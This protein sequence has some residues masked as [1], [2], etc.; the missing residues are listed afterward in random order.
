MKST[1]FVSSLFLAAALA[2]GISNVS[3]SPIAISPPA[4]K[5]GSNFSR[6]PFPAA[7][8][9][10][11]VE[12]PGNTIAYTPSAN[13]RTTIIAQTVSTEPVLAPTGRMTETAVTPVRVRSAMPSITPPAVKDG[14]NFSRAPFPASRTFDDAR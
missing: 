11:D 12:S 13:A 5:D 2:A 9:F 1:H 7:R 4:V 10:N 8:T 3:A 6:A 14:S